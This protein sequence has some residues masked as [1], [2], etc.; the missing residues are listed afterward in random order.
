[1]VCP[2]TQAVRKRHGI[3]NH[4]LYSLSRGK[5][6]TKNQ[7]IKETKSKIM[8][9]QGATV[10]RKA[11]Q[12]WKVLPEEGPGW[13]QPRCA[14]GAALASNAPLSLRTLPVSPSWWSWGPSLPFKQ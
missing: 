13:P 5:A 14:Q 12:R 2:E 11:T 1:M 4:I 3:Q 6:S 7:R 10:P 8:S 9:H